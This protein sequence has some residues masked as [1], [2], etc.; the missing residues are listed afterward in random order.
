[1]ALYGMPPALRPRKGTPEAIILEQLESHGALHQKPA[2]SAP[3]RRA[4]NTD[5]EKN[6][7]PS[8]ETPN[9]NPDPNCMSKENS[10][11]KQQ[12]PATPVTRAK[13]SLRASKLVRRG[14]TARRGGSSAK[15]KSR[16]APDPSFER[17]RRK[18]SVCNHPHREAIEEMF[19]NWHSPESIRVALGAYPPL[20]WSAIYR[21]ARATGLYA[22]RSKNLRAVLDLLL[23][24]AGDVQPTAQGIIA[25]VRAY[26]CLTDA[27][28]WIEPEKRVHIVNRVY[29]HDSPAV[30]DV[31]APAAATAS[32]TSAPEPSVDL[33]SVTAA[34][35]QDQSPSA[36]RADSSAFA[37]SPLTTDHCPLPFPN[38]QPAEL[39]SPPTRT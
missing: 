32:A 3:A 4:E 6:G 26:S 36:P 8:A 13:A 21:H 29:R 18:C 14:E 1:M 9:Q 27:N 20:D 25:V 11:E 19:I 34:R 12:M 22:K 31:P 16:T 5:T 24:K 30:S 33:V 7:Q 37:G 38:R 23:E 35:R 28:Q 17:H 39:E 10:K 15:C 2:N